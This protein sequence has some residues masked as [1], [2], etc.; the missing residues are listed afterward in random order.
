MY[1]NSLTVTNLQALQN[2]C[3]KV[4]HTAII[5]L[6]INGSSSAP[7]FRLLLTGNIRDKRF[8]LTQ[9]KTAREDMASTRLGHALHLSASSFN[10]LSKKMRKKA[11][12]RS[13]GLTKR[14]GVY[15]K[16][17]LPTLCM[18]PI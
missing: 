18:S 16:Q 17:G 15:V 5:E 9:K 10:S 12:N 13:W 8:D 2:A 14:A 4:Q 3:S 7:Q 6:M 11:V 1:K